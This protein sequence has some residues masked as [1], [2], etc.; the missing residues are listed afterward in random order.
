MLSPHLPIVF[1]KIAF[2]D[3]FP[4]VSRSSKQVLSFT[5]LRQIHIH[6]SLHSQ[7]RQRPTSFHFPRFGFPINV[8]KWN[9]VY[10]VKCPRLHLLSP[11]HA[12]IPSAPCLVVSL[13]HSYS[14]SDTPIFAAVQNNSL[15]YSQD[16]KFADLCFCGARASEHRTH[17]LQRN[18]TINSLPDS[19]PTVASL[20]TPTGWSAPQKCK[21]SIVKFAR[22]KFLHVKPNGV[23]VSVYRSCLKVYVTRTQALL[24]CGKCSMSSWYINLCLNSEFIIVYAVTIACHVLVH[25]LYQTRLKPLKIAVLISP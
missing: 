6:T 18:V 15:S 22:N 17:C 7:A 20:R 4:S 1:F 24:L 3:I 9:T 11:S 2:N 23:F 12:Q 8:F 16:Y 19:K 10:I 13:A 21:L 25:C 5:F 14:E